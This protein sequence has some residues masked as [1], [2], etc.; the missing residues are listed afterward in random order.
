MYN[1]TITT[2]NQ[3]S[4]IPGA[5]NIKIAHCLGQNIVV[6]NSTK[7]GDIGIYFPSDGVINTSFLAFNRLL[8]KDPVTG[9]KMGGFFDANCRVRCIKLRGVESDG[10][11]CPLSYLINWAMSTGIDIT[12]ELKEGTELTSFGDIIFCQK[13]YPPYLIERANRMKVDINTIAQSRKPKEAFPLPKHKDTAR[14]TGLG[15]DADQTLYITEKLHGTSGRSGWLKNPNYQVPSYLDRMYSKFVESLTSTAW[16]MLGGL[17]FYIVMLIDGIFEMLGAKL[18]LPE[19]KFYHGSRNLPISN[20][21]FRRDVAD[22]IEMIIKSA[23]R[24][25][26]F[27]ESDDIEVYYEIVGY[28]RNKA[29]QSQSCNQKELTKIYGKQINYT[30]GEKA[31]YH[32]Y[33]VYRLVVNGQEVSYSDTSQYGKFNMVPL[34]QTVNGP[35]TQEEVQAIREQL[36]PSHSASVLDEKQLKE[37]IVLRIETFGTEYE[38]RKSQVFPVSPVVNVYKDKSFAFKLLEGIAKDNG[39][40]DIEEAE[41]VAGE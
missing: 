41:Q 14:W 20:F 30:Y 8:A 29:I 2:L 9:E 36:N 25:G 21:G 16:N 18:P 34:L 19:K 26:V 6:S 31:G 22:N 24:N 7:E 33:Y 37:G 11:W 39:E 13:Y 17:D 28:D 12:M 32:S 4:P 3:F 5:D 10:F 15:L 38:R 1:A 23:I 35:L 40:F 27:Y